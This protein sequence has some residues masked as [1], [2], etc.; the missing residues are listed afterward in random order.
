[1]IKTAHN[2]NHGGGVFNF[3]EFSSFIVWTRLSG[4]KY[5][6]KILIINNYTDSGRKRRFKKMLVVMN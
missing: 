5:S 3:S 4:F 1:M 2:R 6:D